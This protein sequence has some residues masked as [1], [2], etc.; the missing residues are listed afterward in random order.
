MSDQANVSV[1]SGDIFFFDFTSF[2]VARP[3]WI[4]FICDPIT[5]F[6]GHFYD[7]RQDEDEAKR[8]Y[9]K[10]KNSQTSFEEWRSKDLSDCILDPSDL[11]C[12]IEPGQKMSTPIVSHPK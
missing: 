2:H 6:K 4:S 3:N 9:A 10:M 8:Q 11:E 12:N 5:K 1:F 7:K